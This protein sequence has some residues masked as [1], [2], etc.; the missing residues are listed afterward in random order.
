MRT[1]ALTLVALLIVCLNFKGDAAAAAPSKPAVVQTWTCFN[2]VTPTA[3]AGTTS[4]ATNGTNPALILRKLNTGTRTQM[5][6]LDISQ[7]GTV[8]G[9]L[10][11]CVIKLDLVDRY[12]SG[13]NLWT[14]RAKDVTY[15]STT[16]PSFT[17]YDGATA[18]AENAGGAD[19]R[20]IFAGTIF[21]TV[22][23][24]GTGFVYDFQPEDV[25]SNTGA[26]L[27]YLYASSTAPSWQGTLTVIE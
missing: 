2:A 17:L 16:Q 11:T 26:L 3:W 12:S 10:I 9:G 13:G 1:F 25:L 5:K 27:I 8:A 15:P 21:Q 22:T 23:G 20:T 14:L 4:Y 7:T 19:P 6:R 24:L 18:T